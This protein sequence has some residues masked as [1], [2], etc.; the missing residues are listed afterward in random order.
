MTFASPQYAHETPAWPEFHWDH[1]AFGKA[2]ADVHFRRGA[3]VTAM[4]DLGFATQQ[5]TVLEALVQDV[6]QSSEIE[7]KHL[8]AQQVR[9]SIATRLGLDTAGLPVP[10]RHVEGV[11][12]MIL[13]ATQ[14]FEAPLTADRL[15]GWHAALFP[16][17]RSGL[18]R[19]IVGAWRDDRQGPMMVL[20]GAPDRPD[21]QVVHFVAPA[22]DRVPAEMARFLAWFESADLDPVLKAATAH[23]WFLTIHPFDDG[24]GR[25][26][27]AIADLAL[28][29]ADGSRQRYYSMS[30]RI[31]LERQS[32]YR[33]LEETQK[34]GMDV[35]GWIS[36][37]LE[38]LHAALDTTEHLIAQVRF[39][40][41]YWHAHGGQDLNARQRKML[42]AL[43]DGFDSKLRSS[44]YAAFTGCSQPTAVRDLG[45]LVEKK[46]LRVM[47]GTGGRGTAYELVLPAAHP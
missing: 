2:L 21:R 42:N 41:A 9:S 40:R 6:T 14:R 28:A 18:H 12:D 44:K 30:A 27:R 1:T 39:K 10:D 33:V 31:R 46:L 8:D 37:F 25:M 5:E 22:A 3:L 24:N 34:G 13:D 17:G 20:S 43:L 29:R 15:F 4:G 26:A 38:C 11:V 45:D 16:T 19:I 36:W 23:L 47:D 32:Y 7:G 35:T